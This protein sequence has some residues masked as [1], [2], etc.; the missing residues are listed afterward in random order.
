MDH[1]QLHQD[2]IDL[3]RIPSPSGHEGA[4]ADFVRETIAPLGLAVHEDNAG[5]V[6]GSD[7]GN[8]I[9]QTE[10]TGEPL[11]LS[12]HMDTVPPTTKNGTIPVVVE[13][14]RVHTG[15]VSILGGDDKAG[16]AVA[17]AMLREAV[18]APEST[19][20]LDVVFT[21]QEEQGARGARHLDPGALRARE[22][23]NLDGDT[24]VAV[25]IR[26]APHKQRY[27]IDVTGRAAHAALDPEGGINAIQALGA[28]AAALPTGR[29]DEYSIANMGRIEG[30]GAINVVPEH[31]RLIGELRSLNQNQLETIKSQIRVI[32]QEQAARFGAEGRVT[33]EHL[34]A[35]YYVPDDAPIA[36]L[37]TAACANQGHTPQLVST[38][39]GG[40]A[41]PLN[42]KGLQCVVFGLGMQQIH[43]PDEFI[44]LSDLSAAAE[45]LHRAITILQ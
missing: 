29:L 6:L 16:V 32:V 31:A 35:S 43:T 20:P 13:G 30:G 11:F 5:P 22:G 34:Y 27:Y 14:D 38:Y 33:W 41:N 9:I 3:C 4:L 8:L 44:L 17:L 40:D 19:R 37:F 1:Q 7:T 39:G 42:N 21:V 23:F 15:G 28:I 18:R 12:A 2:L 45:I 24:P 26:E 25:A 10:G 36:R